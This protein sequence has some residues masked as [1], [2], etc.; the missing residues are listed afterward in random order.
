MSIQFYERLYSYI[1]D[2]QNLVYDFYSKHASRYLVTY[3]NINKDETIWDDNKLFSGSYERTGNLSGLKFDKILMFPVHWPDEITTSFDG[4]ETGLI[5]ENQTT[6]VIPSSYGIIPYAGDFLKFE[7]SFLRQT[8]DIYPLFRVEGIEI[9]TNTDKRFWKLTV[10]NYESKT[11]QD[12]DDQVLETKVFV[13][14]TKQI[15]QLNDA[16]FLAKML[17]K[18]S[19][20]AKKLKETFDDNSGFYLI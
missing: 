6:L 4:Q 13:E 5:K 3:Y 20:L 2:Y 17:Y 12:I 11:I 8:N 1:H 16:G 9:S 15:Y 10:K 19:I 18:H 14:Y 7:Q